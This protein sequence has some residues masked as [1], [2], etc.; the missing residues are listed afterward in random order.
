MRWFGQYR[1]SAVCDDTQRIAVPVGEVCPGCGHPIEEGDDGYVIPLLGH[2]RV[3]ELS[4]HED[5]LSFRSIGSPWCGSDDV[6]LTVPQHRRY[7]DLRDSG[8]RPRSA[9]AQVQA[10]FKEST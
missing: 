1:F 10:E 3:E 7:H 9:I 6:S 5:C 8:V 4:W 2:D